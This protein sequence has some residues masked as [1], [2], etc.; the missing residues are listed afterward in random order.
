M[1][2]TGRREYIGGWHTERLAPRPRVLCTTIDKST[3]SCS[4]ESK[5]HRIVLLPI[6]CQGVCYIKCIDVYLYR[7]EKRSWPS[8]RREREWPLCWHQH[9]TD[10]KNRVFMG[11]PPP[12]LLLGWDDGTWRG[13]RRLSVFWCS[14]FFFPTRSFLDSIQPDLILFFTRRLDFNFFFFNIFLSVHHCAAHNRLVFPPQNLFNSLHL[15]SILFRYIPAGEINKCTEKKEEEEEKLFNRQ[16][17]A[18]GYT[19]VVYKWKYWIY[20]CMDV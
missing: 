17:R 3:S 10:R 1:R 15:H 2:L 4:Q 14:F 13:R 18:A 19:P 9:R 6:L 5:E 11:D 7:R 12:L 20:V 16:E 8:T